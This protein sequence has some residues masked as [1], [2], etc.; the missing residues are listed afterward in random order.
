MPNRVAAPI[1]DKPCGSMI[2][3]HNQAPGCTAKLA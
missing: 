3:L 2:S 1:T